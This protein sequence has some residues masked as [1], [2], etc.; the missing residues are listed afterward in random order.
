M[1][2]S[3]GS[4]AISGP[5]GTSVLMAAGEAQ[6]LALTALNR[7]F[8]KRAPQL[9][10]FMPDAKGDA[11]AAAL[12]W[13]GTGPPTTRGRNQPSKA[14]RGTQTGNHPL[15]PTTGTRRCEYLGKKNGV[16][17]SFDIDR[18]TKAAEFMAGSVRQYM[19]AAPTGLPHQATQG[20]VLQAFKIARE[21]A[22]AKLAALRAPDAF[23]DDIDHA[24]ACATALEGTHREPLG[25][26]HASTAQ[27]R[28]PRRPPPRGCTPR[29]QAQLAR[30]AGHL[31]GPGPAYTAAI[32][33]AVVG[34][35]GG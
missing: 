13:C 24:L 25:T 28:P 2:G 5:D 14:L 6:E 33:K 7:V 15:G 17:A 29:A 12:A 9:G 35:R 26:G 1:G 10:T 21:H 16:A 34:G 30:R 23:K 19:S 20:L 22:E 4:H 18:L 8:A 32:R 31:P 27:P 11:I 3:N